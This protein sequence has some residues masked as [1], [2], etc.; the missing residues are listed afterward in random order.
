M[1][2]QEQNVQCMCQLRMKIVKFICLSNL[3]LN[4]LR[5]VAI[6]FFRVISNKLNSRIYSQVLINPKVSFNLKLF[7]LGLP[8]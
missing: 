1:D 2:T 7:N 8:C 6:E 3:M 5:L 4:F